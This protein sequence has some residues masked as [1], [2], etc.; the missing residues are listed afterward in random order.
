M[1][2]ICS[3]QGAGSTA[4]EPQMACMMKFLVPNCYKNLKALVIS[5]WPVYVQ[6]CF[7]MVLKFLL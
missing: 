2:A 6:E 5:W 4:G 3:E 7:P 1:L